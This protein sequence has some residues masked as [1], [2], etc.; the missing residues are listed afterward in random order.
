[1]LKIND[2]ERALVLFRKAIYLSEVED[3]THEQVVFYESAIGIAI[4]LGKFNDAIDLINDSLKVLD[5]VG[6]IEQITKCILTVVLIH[7]YRDD[8]VSAKNYMENIKNKYEMTA[9]NHTFS[10]VDQ[11]I[12]AFDEKDDDAFKDLTKNYLNYA[13]DNEVLK[14]AHKIVKS[15]EW[16]KH[17]N[18]STTKSDNISSNIKTFDSNKTVPPVST[19]VPPPETTSPLSELEQLELNEDTSFPQPAVD[20]NPVNNNESETKTTTKADSDEEEELD[21]C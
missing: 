14:L 21:L 8:W 10:R 1:M 7:L 11:I 9:S 18:V 2:P 13:V 15:D 3:K 6:K 12:D 5:Q 20:S 16:L 17:Q 4:K 19:T